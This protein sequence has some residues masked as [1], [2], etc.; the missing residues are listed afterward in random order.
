MKALLLMRSNH[1][2]KGISL[3]IKPA[4]I[5][6]VNALSIAQSAPVCLTAAWDIV[7][8]QRGVIHCINA[9]KLRTEF[10]IALYLLPNSLTG[11]SESQGEFECI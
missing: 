6:P 9:Y 5:D 7:L 10:R 8:D 4:V 2:L 3:K 1:Q 11:V